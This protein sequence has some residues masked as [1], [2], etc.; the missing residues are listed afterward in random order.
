MGK[1]KWL[2]GYNYETFHTA[3]KSSISVFTLLDP[4]KSTNH[5]TSLRPSAIATNTRQSSLP[6]LCVYNFSRKASFLRIIRVIYRLIPDWTMSML[7][8]ERHCRNG[9]V[10]A[11]TL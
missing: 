8:N 10:P 9:P 1:I 11:R 7:Y 6:S 5:I 4:P 3:I 2:D